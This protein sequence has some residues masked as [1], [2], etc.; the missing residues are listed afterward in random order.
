M[1]DLSGYVLPLGGP[2]SR[3]EL[4]YNTAPDFLGLRG[5]PLSRLVSIQQNVNDD[6]LE[7]VFEYMPSDG[8]VQLTSSFLEDVGDSRLKQKVWFDYTVGPMN[9]VDLQVR[10]TSIELP[11]G[12][13]GFAPSL[14]SPAALPFVGFSVVFNDGD[15]RIDRTVQGDFL[16][17]YRRIG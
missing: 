10:G 15:L 8:V 13:N 6:R 17:I 11:F 1:E 5:G 16:Y 9:K 3:W 14:S 4:I 12:G 2:P 7:I